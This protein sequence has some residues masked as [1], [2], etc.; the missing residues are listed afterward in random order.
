MSDA[1][2]D[3]TTCYLPA[4][5]KLLGNGMH[6]GHHPLQLQYRHLALMCGGIRFWMQNPPLHPSHQSQR[7]LRLLELDSLLL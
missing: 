1:K 4:V 7:L 5:P 2:L 6:R 3:V